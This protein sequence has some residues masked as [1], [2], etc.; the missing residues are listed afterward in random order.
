MDIGN[1]CFLRLQIIYSK[2][3]LNII[4]KPTKV[5]WSLLYNSCFLEY[6]NKPFLC[7]CCTDMSLT[8]SSEPSRTYWRQTVPLTLSE[9]RTASWNSTLECWDVF[10]SIFLLSLSRYL[11]EQSDAQLD[12][13]PEHELIPER[14]Y[15]RVTISGEEKCGVRKEIHLYLRKKKNYDQCDL[16]SNVQDFKMQLNELKKTPDK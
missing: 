1:W 14:E 12:L 16:Y 2:A 3:K 11:K 7:Y 9:F 4:F 13:Y 6:I 5:I 10:K 8:F 15:Q